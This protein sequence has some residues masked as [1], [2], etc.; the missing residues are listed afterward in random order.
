MA[1]GY[2]IQKTQKPLTV[3]H[4]RDVPV[5]ED[6]E[7]ETATVFTSACDL[8][9]FI[10]KCLSENYGWDNFVLGEG[11]YQQAADVEETSWKVVLAQA[12]RPSGGEW[13]G[14][15]PSRQRSLVRNLVSS[16]RVSEVVTLSREEAEKLI[17]ER[18]GDLDGK[19]YTLSC[20]NSSSIF[21]SLV[22]LSLKMMEYAT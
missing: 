1:D 9:E 7:R 19:I 11:N 4:C 6:G 2:R 12:Y 21:T 3:W 10:E 14:L 16:S 8:A 18:Y 20:F 5:V 13:D 17:V 22:A 15:S